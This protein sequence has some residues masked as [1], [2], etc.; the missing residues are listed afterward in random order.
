MTSSPLA[1]FLEDQP[2]VVLDGGLATALEAAGHVLDTPLWSA[3]LLLDD[4]EAVRSVHASYLEAGADC[5]L[6]AG[7]QASVPGLVAAGLDRAAAEALLRRAVTLA[8]EARDAF[9]ADAENRGGRRRPLVAA[10]AGPYGAYLADGSEYRGDY[11]VDRAV[12]ERFHGERLGAIADAGA[13]L[14]AFETIP[15]GLEAEVVAGLLADRP[16]V[17]AWVTFTC[18]DGESLRDG[19]P[20]AEAAAVFAAVGSLVGVGVNCTAPALVGPLIDRIA[21]VTDLPLVAYPNS[22]ERYDAAAHAW[23]GPR[24]AWLER[25]GDWVAAGAR[26]VG[27]CCRVGPGEIRELRKRM[28]A[29]HAL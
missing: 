27:G 23:T 24:A 10:S 1:P 29:M 28:E 18:S 4:P 16:D 9:W 5:V 26:V 25:V 14:V 3:R 20:A 8:G 2:F 12:L 13:D 6:T 22:G 21:G 11:G 15:S 7:Y 19:T 17:P